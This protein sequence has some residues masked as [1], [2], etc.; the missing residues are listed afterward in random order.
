[1][2]FALHPEI[3]DLNTR[4]IYEFECDKVKLKF[5]R[6]TVIGWDGSKALVTMDSYN[7]LEADMHKDLVGSGGAFML[8]IDARH[9]N[10]S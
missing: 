9:E 2:P 5:A 4:V 10:R 7:S 3:E 1:M 6:N 8:A